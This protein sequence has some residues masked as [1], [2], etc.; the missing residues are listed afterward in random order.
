MLKHDMAG[1]LLAWLPAS[2]MVSDL[3]KYE[4]QTLASVGNHFACYA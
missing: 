2:K 3:F 4:A 1:A